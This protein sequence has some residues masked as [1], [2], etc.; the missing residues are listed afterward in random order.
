MTR[1]LLSEDEPVLARNIARSLEREG[2]QVIHAAS[3]AETR[4]ALEEGHFDLV[5]AD[6]SLGDGDGLDVVGDAS[7]GLQG[8]PVI[9]MTGEDS[10]SNRARA[11]CLPVAA[12][13]SKPFA[14]ARLRELV[15]A[16]TRRS[17]GEPRR[18]KGPSVV[19]YSHDTLGLGHMRRNSSIARELVAQV[20]DISVLMLVGCPAGMVFEPCAGVDYV[21]L[22]SL[23]KLGRD[24]FEAGSLR[25]DAETTRDMRARIIGGV[26]TSIDPDIFLVDHEPGGAMDELRPILAQLQKNPRVRTVL[27]LRDILDDPVR[28]R[29]AW[30][31][32]GTN[33][34]I[35]ESYDHVLVYGDAEFFP[36]AESYGLHSLKPGA[37]TE[38]GVV[39]TVRTMPRTPTPRVPRRILVSGGGGRDAYPLIETAIRAVQSIPARRRPEV[40]VITGPL[41]DAEL[42]D[43]AL[44][45]GATAGIEVLEHVS[46]LPALMRDA[47]LLVTMT[48]YNSINEALAIGCPI[49]TVPR[50]GPSAEQ[51]LRA[52]ALEA[53]GLAVYLRR[54]DLTPQSLARLMRRVPPAVPSGRLNTDGVRKAAGVL[55]RMIH[56]LRETRK[57]RAH[58]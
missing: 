33:Q 24:A 16:L 46:D 30:A 45:L 52:E 8:T 11:E 49:V 10:V 47:D 48:G 54:E 18:G 44:R 26:I 38:C 32:R 40:T 58:A 4:L 29:S 28:T 42:R 34:L 17:A 31:A 35:A 9:V 19:M 15:G 21:K 1:I 37:V 14:L 51:R 56:D 27:G 50:L 43:E 2:T 23:N 7:P 6:I 25:I 13:L 22:P 3:A 57:E 39:T 20:P 12:F 36:S 41:M 53:A 5:I 55:A